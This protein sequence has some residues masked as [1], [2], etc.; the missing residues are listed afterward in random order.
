MRSDWVDLSVDLEQ[1][2][3]RRMPASTLELELELAILRVEGAQREVRAASKDDEKQAKFHLNMAVGHLSKLTKLHPGLPT[4]TPPKKKKPKKKGDLVPPAHENQ[5][6]YMRSEYRGQGERRFV[7]DFRPGQET[8]GYSAQRRL[9]V[10]NITGGKG[11]LVEVEG[12][13][14]VYGVPYFVRDAFGEFEETMQR[15]VASHLIDT[16]DCRFLFGHDGLPLARTKSGTMKLADTASALRFTATV[17]TRQQLA[18][19]LVIAIELGHVSS[20][21]V[22]MV[23]AQDVWSPDYT[24]REV[25]RLDALLDVSAVTYPASPTTSIALAGVGRA[26]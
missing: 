23:V 22:G 13:P 3:D 15:G 16:A 18:N 24:K 21:S 17:D 12:A 11:T 1:L 10:R 20:M 25:S 8:R 6:V 14:I 4:W 2:R 9:E 7:A 5:L 19:D 26:R